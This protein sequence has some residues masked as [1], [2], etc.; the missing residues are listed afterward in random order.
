MSLEF[1]SPFDAAK[2]QVARIGVSSLDV[3]SVDAFYATADGY[4]QALLDF[5]LITESQS[6]Q[7]Q[8]EMREA[9]SDAIE[10]IKKNA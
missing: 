9:R 8:A 7:L 3:E 1:E 6:N 10:R 2:S 5:D 4:I